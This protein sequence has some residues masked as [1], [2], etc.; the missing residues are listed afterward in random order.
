MTNAYT[1]EQKIQSEKIAKQRAEA[2]RHERLKKIAETLAR[3][4]EL[5]KKMMEGKK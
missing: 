3:N 4:S 1:A 5:K 2:A